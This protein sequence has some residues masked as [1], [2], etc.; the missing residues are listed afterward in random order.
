M[1]GVL[2]ASRMAFDAYGKTDLP[3][4]GIIAGGVALAYLLAGFGN[5]FCAALCQQR[6]HRHGRDDHAGGFHHFPVHDPDGKYGHEG[7]SGLAAYPRRHP[8]FVRLVDS[9]GTGHRVLDAAGHDS[10]LAIC[11]ALF[12]LGLMSDYFFGRRAELGSW[13]ASALY[14]IVPN[15][16]FSGSLMRWTWAKALFQWGYVA[17]AFCYVVGY[18]GAAL[19]IATAMFE[20]RELS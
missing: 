8:G 3:A 18:A 13:W 1:I 12:L 9:G 6:R 2:I 14:T 4:I 16:S 19:A 7:G 20:E 5:F 15:C 10:T 17:K 11:S